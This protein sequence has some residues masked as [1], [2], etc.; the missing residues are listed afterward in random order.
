MKT[1]VKKFLDNQISRRDFVKGVAALGVSLSS[2]QALLGSIS[3]SSAYAAEGVGAQVSREVT[4]N[5][6]D[7]MMESLMD[8][9]VKYIFHGCGGGTNRFF[10]SVVT[11]PKF[12]NFLATNEGQCVAMAEGYHIASGELGVVI[13]PKPGLGNAI[14][15]IHNALADMSSLLIITARESNEWSERQGDI[16]IID[17]QKVMDP[18]MKWSYKMEHLKRVPEF[19]R[20]A[21][22]VSLTPPGGPTFLQMTED[23][24]ENEGKA[25]IISQKKFQVAGKIKPKPELITEVAQ[26]LIESK[27]PLITVGLEVTKAGAQEKIIELSELLAIPVTQGWSCFADFPNRH[28]LS[29]GRYTPYLMYAGNADLYLVIGSQMPDEGNYTLPGPPPPRAKV[30]HVSLE[31]KLLAMSYPTDVSIVADAKEAISDLIEAIKSLATKERLTTIKNE[32]YGRIKAQGDDARKKRAEE[33]KQSWDKVPM[34][35]ARVI[36]ELNELLENDAIIVTEPMTPPWGLEWLDLGYGKKT[37]I[38]AS[39]GEVLGWS[40]GVAAGAKLAKPDTQ[41]VAL[42]GDGAFMFQNS[43]WSLARYDAPVIVVVLNNRCYNMNR[44]FGNLGGGAQAKLQKN[45][46]CYLGDP[47]VD[48]SLMAKSYGV[49]SEVVKD[50][51]ELKPAI[52]RAIKATKDG[53]PYLLDVNVERWG[54]RGEDTFHPEISI[55]GMRTKKI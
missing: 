20:R 7:L 36:C 24:F 32:R 47:D 12:K 39:P 38:G 29:L 37:L 15:S 5:G 23:L 31:A 27:N 11:R 30:I 51:S 6:S 2:A 16:E 19:T 3:D 14:G 41:V 17:W 48:F 34:T 50:P 33:A 4:G 25:Q 40:T 52:N 49:D 1:L 35:T 8:A 44:A 22:K 45:I 9:D 54:S 21:I 26:M 55:A 28:P 13:L 46:V 53:N 18:L 43:L 42:T 10:D